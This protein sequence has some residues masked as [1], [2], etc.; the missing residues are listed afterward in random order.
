MY[1]TPPEFLGE[2]VHSVL[3]QTDPR[4]E[5]LLVNDGSGE[6][7]TV[8][9][10]QIA[11]LDTQRIGYYD[12]AGRGT[13]PGPPR[14]LGIE[15]ARG[16]YIA[17]LDAD[18]VWYP[19]KV[20]EQI[21][22]LQSHPEAD[23]IWGNT[24]YWYSWAGSSAAVHTDHIPPQLAQTDTTYKPPTL[25]E[26]LLSGEM[27]LPCMCS[28]VVSRETID[29]C[30]GFLD[31]IPTIF[32]DQVFVAKICL[33][34]SVYVSSKCWDRY[35]QWDDSTCP[36]A[37]RAGAVAA[38]RRNYYQWLSGY[39]ASHPR[40]TT[41]LLAQ[42]QRQASLAQAGPMSPRRLFQVLRKFRRKLWKQR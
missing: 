39:V 37:D 11:E 21:E 6:A 20:E 1:D 8:A 34:G 9:A 14:N 13:G 4:W 7:S 19:R 26:K 12:H 36:K 31:T 23:A 5:L 15:M 16:A 24:E 33:Q 30:G 27:P 17:F 42:V 22:L 25:L 32:E 38:A 2:A 40:G 18:D 10:R 28:L 3:N 35:R 41:D 29:E